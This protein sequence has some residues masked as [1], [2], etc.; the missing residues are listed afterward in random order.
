MTAHYLQDIDPIFALMVAIV[1]RALG[2]LRSSDP[3]ARDRT[4]QWFTS[5]HKD[6]I[7]SYQAIKEFL[8][9]EISG[10]EVVEQVLKG[11]RVNPYQ[12]PYYTKLPEG[13]R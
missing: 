7:F 10:T 9:L 3:K 6:Y 5:E 2:D 8:G 12:A 1:Q 13:S 11:R 4:I